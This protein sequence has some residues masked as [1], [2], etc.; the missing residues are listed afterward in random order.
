LLVG[1]CPDL[2][3]RV[4]PIGRPGGL[5]YRAVNEASAVP[6]RL[7]TKEETRLLPF[8]P[9]VAPADREAFSAEVIDRMVQA[10]RPPDS[11]CFEL[12]R[13]VHLFFRGRYL[14]T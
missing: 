14:P 5:P 9:W 3:V 8:L 2:V 11:R 13:R 4:L 7:Q 1:S 6:V 10:T 12:L